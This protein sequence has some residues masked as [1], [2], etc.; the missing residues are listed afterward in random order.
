MDL[1]LEILTE[2]IPA[3][4]LPSVRQQ[5]ARG[6]GDGL[7]AAG[8][9]PSEL[10]ILSTARRLV[11]LA[12]GVPERPADRSEVL[13]GPPMPRPTIPNTGFSSNPSGASSTK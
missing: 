10:H 4:A 1:L 13:T 5:L 12:R 7:A 8:L 9:P 6:F 3:A 2:E 11:V